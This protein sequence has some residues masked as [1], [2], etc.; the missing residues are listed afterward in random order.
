MGRWVYLEQLGCPKN[1]VDG[2]HLLGALRRA[3]FRRA[4]SPA[5]SDVLLVN[6]CGFIDP[7]KRESI[8]RILALARCKNGGGKRLLVAGCLAQRYPRELLA[9]IPE[10]DA[11]VGVDRLDEIVRAA[12]GDAVGNCF[13]ARPARRYEESTAPRERPAS[14]W[15]YLKISDGCDNACAFCAIPQF[16]GRHRS[17]SFEA[18][19]AEAEGL[20]AS[21]VREL[22]VVAQ[23]T[24]SYGLDRY[25]RRRLAELLVRLGEVPGLVWVRLMYAFPF[26][27]DEP[28]IET[29]AGAPGVAR[30]L[31][32]PIQHIDDDLLGRMNR[33]LGGPETRALLERIRR[34]APKIALRTSVVVGHP[35]ES[36]AAFGSLVDFIADFEF[37]RLGVF[38]YSEEA[39]T[40]AAGMEPKID[41]AT[42]E[43]RRRMVLD[44]QSDVLVR[45]QEAQV[46]RLVDALVETHEDDAWWG[47]TQ[48]DAPE[49]DCAIR[50]EGNTRAGKLVRVRCTR[51]EGVD[52]VGEPES[53]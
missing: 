39:G 24:T 7:A 4:D 2:E 31:D 47:R 19:I 29:L 23:D 53:A 46:G 8:E 35:A 49:V 37:D 34:V 13:V 12:R 30:Y 10:I 14:P 28:L 15:A 25:G 20:V 9:E 33:R 48:A 16:R 51:T 50:I 3:G 1:E 43:L 27:V 40:P 11:L 32:L 52:L 6:T 41:T 26:F 38:L 21:G 18:I 17:R 42:A 22:T 36:A 44:V 5:D 45:R